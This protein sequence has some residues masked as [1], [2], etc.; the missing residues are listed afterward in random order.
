MTRLLALV[1]L[2]LCSFPVLA[3]ATFEELAGF[4]KVAV[5]IA[6]SSKD[7]ELHNDMHAHLKAEKCWSYLRGFQE[8]LAWQAI[9]RAQ[10]KD[11]KDM[12]DVIA[13]LPFCI[14]EGVTLKQQALMLIN[15]AGRKTEQNSWPGGAVVGD[16]M[17]EYFPC[18]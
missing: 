10:E 15:L 2:M 9:Q 18:K 1:V 5:D 14:P 13:E 7:D 11:A 16:M 4:C 12:Q 6:E 17:Q 8:A 3:A